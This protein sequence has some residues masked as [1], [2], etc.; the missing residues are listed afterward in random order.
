M[1]QPLVGQLAAL[2]PTEAH[3]A[4]NTHLQ[5]MKSPQ[6]EVGEAQMKLWPCGKPA[7]QQSFGSCRTMERGAHTGVGLLTG[8]VTL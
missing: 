2:Q 8:L 4:A 6:V 1:V 3:G 5:P 7:L